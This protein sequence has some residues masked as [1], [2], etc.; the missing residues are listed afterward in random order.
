MI[1]D[2]W[3]SPNFMITQLLLEVFDAEKRVAWNECQSQPLAEKQSVK[4]LLGDE[5][6]VNV[7]GLLID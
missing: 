3:L 6:E 1:D 7:V 5:L 4:S 2:T